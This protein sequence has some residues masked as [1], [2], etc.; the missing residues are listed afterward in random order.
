MQEKSKNIIKKYIK[1]LFP[2]FIATNLVTFPLKSQI[3]I[4]SSRTSS[5]IYKTN[6]GVS[7][8]RQTRLILF[9]CKAAY[10]NRILQ[11]CKYK[12]PA[13]SYILRS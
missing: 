6:P 10:I 1:K 13:V 12:S 11:I 3:F 5:L 9:Y 8:H 4:S 7:L 2:T